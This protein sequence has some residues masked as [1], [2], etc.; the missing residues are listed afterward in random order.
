M[1]DSDTKSRSDSNQ[2]GF[3]LLDKLVD[4]KSLRS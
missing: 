2:G 1:C 3:L 4:L